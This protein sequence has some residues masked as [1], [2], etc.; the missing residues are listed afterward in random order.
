ME[1]YDADM[2]WKRFKGLSKK[3]LPVIL[4]SDIKQATISTWRRRKRFPR[5]DEAVKIA[6]ILDTTVEYLV[7][8]RE[9]SYSTC[10]T[11]ALEI[12][13]AADRLNSEGKQIILKIIKGLE[14][15]YPLGSLRSIDTENA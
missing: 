3:D 13:V 7:T 10:T 8:G 5:A 11:E 14:S 9:K 15:Q 4:K 2:F 1:E 12:A 6:D